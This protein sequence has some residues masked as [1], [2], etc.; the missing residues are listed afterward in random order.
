MAA[1]EAAMANDVSLT[2]V[3]RVPV[4]AIGLNAGMHASAGYRAHLAAVEFEEAVA[5]CLA[6]T[7]RDPT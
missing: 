4:A 5:A 7:A 1:H 3:K 6:S 2:A